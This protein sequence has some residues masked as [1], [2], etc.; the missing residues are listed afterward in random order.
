MEIVYNR[1]LKIMSYFFHL[2]HCLYGICLLL[3]GSDYFYA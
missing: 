2:E 3:K 1:I